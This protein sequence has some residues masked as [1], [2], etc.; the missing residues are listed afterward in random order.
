LIPPAL[1]QP[2]VFS[3]YTSGMS[4]MSDESSQKSFLPNEPSENGDRPPAL[5]DSPVLAQ[6][7]SQFGQTMSQ[8]FELQ[9]GQQRVTERFLES[10]ERILMAVLQA[11]PAN[12]QPSSDGHHGVPAVARL[13]SM[14][15]SLA[16]APPVLNPQRSTLNTQLSP[17]NPQLSTLNSLT[18]APAP[19]VPSAPRPMLVVKP[20]L[21]VA[22]SKD[23]SSSRPLPAVRVRENA[24][25]DRPLVAPPTEEFR[26]DLLEAISQR[27][28]YP[29][30]MLKEDALLEADLGID[31]IKTVEIFSSLTKYHQFLPGSGFEGDEESLSEFAQMKTLRD[32]IKA[33]DKKRNEVH[34]PIQRLEV[35]AALAPP[36]E[37][38]KKKTSR[39][40]IAS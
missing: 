18:S 14:P 26:H 29:K 5:A 22:P 4:N 23:A 6:M 10:Q 2:V 8:W 17:L 21:E 28:G 32:I 24:P 12:G 36:A 30:E 13:A 39:S 20:A 11:P 31:S 33:Y 34:G 38:G 19:A 40:A 3:T 9:A 16:S 7:L 37:D 35:K 1:G 27:T 15:P 25:P